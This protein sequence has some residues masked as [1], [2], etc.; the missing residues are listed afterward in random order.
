MIK[1]VIHDP[2]I[3]GVKSGN[4]TRADLQVGFI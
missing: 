4:A 3:L 2:I 1:Q